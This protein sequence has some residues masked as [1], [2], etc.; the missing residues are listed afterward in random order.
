MLPRPRNSVSS[1]SV[2][3]L[4]TAPYGLQV[5]IVLQ[6]PLLS[7]LDQFLGVLRKLLIIRLQPFQ[8]VVLGATSP[9]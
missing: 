9:D 3:Q 6:V 8:S 4:Y 5:R 1:C 7:W 2:V